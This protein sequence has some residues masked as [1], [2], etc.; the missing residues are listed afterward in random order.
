MPTPAL[1]QL[2]LEYAGATDVGLR[3][4][5]N[6][7]AWWAG[8]LSSFASDLISKGSGR[9]ELDAGAWLGVSDG[10][11]GANA[12]EVASRIAVQET[13]GLIADS[14][15]E[16]HPIKIAHDALLKSNKAIL[17]ASCSNP[18]WGGMGATL[19]FLWIEGVRVVV[20]QVGDSRIYRLRDDWLEEL[21]VDHSPVGR[22]RQGGQLSET[23]ARAHPGRHV[24]DQCLGGGD[25]GLAPDCDLTTIRA[26]DALLICSDGL[27]DG[28]QD[29]EIAGFL[30]AV[31][32]GEMT[33]ESAADGLV[34]R[35]NHLSGRD[36]VTVIVARCVALDAK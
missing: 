23:D 4:A 30:G 13:Q 20:G 18:Q 9:L 29:A 10:L 11:G 22:L 36:N 12:G 25:A 7:D 16:G 33:L 27:N 19:S 32:R 34:Q 35:A 3:R 31:S 28:V 8:P 21:S 6:E 17:R 24:I 26:G 1:S 14:R 2:V 5:N 15:A